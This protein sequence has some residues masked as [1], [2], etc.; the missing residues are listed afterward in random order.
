MPANI[1]YPK[2]LSG[3]SV[4]PT[5]NWILIYLEIYNNFNPNDN[6]YSNITQEELYISAVYGGTCIK[7]NWENG[8][9]N[10]FEISNNSVSFSISE[11]EYY[12]I[13]TSSM[14]DINNFSNLVYAA[15]GI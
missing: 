9:K 8:T 14:L 4:T 1:V 2:A 7:S 6:T 15:L 5:T 3:Y 11:G 12:D 13:G 10:Y